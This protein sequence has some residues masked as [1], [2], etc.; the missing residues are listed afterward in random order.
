ML[1][2][3]P[4]SL[5]ALALVLGFLMLPVSPAAAA[6]R[7]ADDGALL[8][9]LAGLREMNAVGFNLRLKKSYFAELS[10]DDL[11]GLSALF[12][13]AGMTDY[14]LT[15]SS[16]GNL[17]LDDVKWTEPH[18]ASC[19][20]EEGF[21]EA[22]RDLLSRRVP[23][24]QIIVTDE[25]VFDD[26]AAGKLVFLFIAMYG[27]E[28]AAVR[29]TL[30][31]PYAF[32]L[33]EIKYYDVPW[34]VVS[35]EEDLLAAVR[36]RAGENAGEFYL[37]PDPAFAEAVSAGEET[38]KRLETAGA[39]F[40]FLYTYS[41]G[42]LI[43]VRVSPRYPGTRIVNAMREEN[44]LDLNHRERETL[45]AALDLAEACRRDDPL[46]TALLIHDALCKRIV[47]TDDDSTDED[48]N[49]IGAL[50]DGR[51]N[52]DGYADAFYLAGTLAG[53]EVR[54]QHG[55]SRQQEA[56][57]SSGDVSHMWN[58]IRIDGTWRMVDV[59]WDDQ[60]SRTVH[61]WFNIGADRARQTHEWDEENSPPL[62]EKTDPAGRPADD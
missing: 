62:L 55:N 21:R 27:A 60:E 29:T 36:E 28:E 24:C 9:E 17:T 25:K 7:I 30:R 10:E 46:E 20:T 51:A 45:S 18:T 31:E 40:Q 23:A 35:G 52:C 54:Y 16:D 59:T 14:R 34:V 48:D 12:L 49:A 19:S 2:R 1:K 56:D 37:V 50:L 22:I 5:L 3:V 32:Y 53:L 47:Y 8:E 15:Y 61:N 42:L 58:L 4:R 43:R 33:N 38:L 44:W 6:G 26:L 13:S 41:D 39:A 11:A 57:R